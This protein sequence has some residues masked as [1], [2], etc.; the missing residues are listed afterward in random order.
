[1]K[2]NVLYPLPQII[3]SGNNVSDWNA[4]RAR[5]AAELIDVEY[6]GLPPQPEYFDLENIHTPGPG[7]LN[8]Y[9]IH[10]GRPGNNLSY[11][12]Q[13]YRPKKDGRVP[14]VLTGDG[15]YRYFNDTVIDE[16]LSRG[17]AAARFNRTE[18]VS[19]VYAYDIVRASPL[20][21]IYPDID[22]GSIAGWAWGF[23]RSMDALEKLNFVDVHRVAFTG[24]SR[25]GKTALLAGAVDLRAAYVN[26]N[27]SGAAGAGCYRYR[28]QLPDADS[29]LTDLRSERLSDL[30]RVV[31]FWLG[32]KIKQY[33]QDET[34]LPF[35]QH[36]LKA[37]VAPRYLLQTEGV[38]DIWA[39]PIGTHYTLLAAR[40][41]YSALGAE[42][43]IL[44]RYRPGG[45]C[46]KTEDFCAL[47]DM[48]EHDIHGTQLSQDFFAPP[49]RM[50]ISDET[51][52]NTR[53]R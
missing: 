45:H 23:M 16:I 43:R 27:G 34:A 19:D 5:I 20:Y 10:A 26:P 3:G 47:L 39:N 38:D 1:M 36:F 52:T 7:R 8:T 24:H 13:I 49:Y 51:N 18:I 53:I 29:S 46:H 22:S 17:F 42:N 32:P 30:L 35:D 11:C 14:V 50:K 15:C 9:R 33:E 48:M 44:S 40:E 6:G 21:D 37:L 4:R 41:L 12:L 2:D 28:M 31:P 25:G